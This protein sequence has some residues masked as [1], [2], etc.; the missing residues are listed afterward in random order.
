MKLFNIILTILREYNHVLK[1][2]RKQ[3]I[4]QIIKIGVTDILIVIAKI[5]WTGEIMIFIILIAVGEQ[6]TQKQVQINDIMSVVS[7]IT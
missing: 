5:V 4:V 7:T 2:K 6:N 3:I 1:E